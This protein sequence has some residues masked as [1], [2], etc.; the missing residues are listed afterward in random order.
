MRRKKISLQKAIE[1][2]R[3]I[4]HI[5]PPNSH[6]EVS[7]FVDLW[8]VIKDTKLINNVEDDIR[9]RWTESGEYTTKSAS[10][11]QFQGNELFQTQNYANMEGQDGIEMQILRM[12]TNAQKKLTANNLMKRGSTD[13]PMCKLCANDQETPAHMCK[14]CPFTKEVWELIKV[15][16]G[17]TD[18][19]SINTIGSLHNYW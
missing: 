2:N 14:D 16:F 6:V 7:E 5:Y 11:I 19:S 9:W 12:D 15:W 3:W 18:L 1:N 4:D 17:L 13:D 10:K 8:E